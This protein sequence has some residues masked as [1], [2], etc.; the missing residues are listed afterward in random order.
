MVRS[1]KLQIGGGNRRQEIVH[2]AARLFRDRGFHGTTVRDIALA[3][4]MHSG[5]L[6]YHFPSKNDILHAGTMEGLASCLAELE[7]IPVDEM[8]P[9]DYFRVL[10]RTQL[11]HLLS[12][13]TGLAPLV[14]D[15]WRHLTGALRDEVMSLR[16]RYEALW[17][18]AYERLAHAVGLSRHEKF[19]CWFFLGALLGTKNWYVRGGEKTPQELGDVLVDWLLA[20]YLK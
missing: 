3:V 15:E 6:F 17:L 18:A 11:D 1:K 12:D 13:R 20:P 19:S 10:T 7:A 16:N 2:A 14:V 8:T 4:H 5:S 9:I